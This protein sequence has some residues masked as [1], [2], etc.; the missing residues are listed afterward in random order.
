[1]D[2]SYCGWRE[3]GHATGCPDNRDSVSNKDKWRLWNLGWDEGRVGNECLS[4]DPSFVLGYD[5]GTIALE[6]S[7]N[8]SD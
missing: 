8:G 3:G 7:Q 1:M 4:G 6:S 2:C 5:R